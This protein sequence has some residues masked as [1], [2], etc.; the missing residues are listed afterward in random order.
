MGLG[1]SNDI[2]YKGMLFHIETEDRGP[3]NPAIITNLFWKGIILYTKR[4]NYGDVIKFE[5]LGELVLELMKKQHREVISELCSGK[6]D[7][8][9]NEKVGFH[10]G[11]Q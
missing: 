10:G 3:G 6:L 8:L 9:I 5:R 11:R 1:F 7:N 4:I 2:S